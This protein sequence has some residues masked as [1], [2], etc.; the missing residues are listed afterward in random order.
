MWGSLELP[1]RAMLYVRRQTMAKIPSGAM[2]FA[3]KLMLAARLVE[4][5]APIIERSRRV[6][7]GIVVDGGYVKAPLALPCCG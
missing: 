3:T 1:L 7:A 2:P 4:L 6:N 5:I